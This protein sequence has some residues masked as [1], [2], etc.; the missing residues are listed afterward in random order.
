VP[1]P[2]SNRLRAALF[3]TDAA[4]IDAPSRELRLMSVA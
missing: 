1:S 4:R 2:P 3:P